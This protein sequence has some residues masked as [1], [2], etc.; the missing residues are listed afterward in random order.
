M[1]LEMK[2]M[3]EEYLGKKSPGLTDPNTRPSVDLPLAKVKP[4]NH[5]SPSTENNGALPKENDGQAKGASIP[6]Q[7]L[8][9]LYLFIILCFDTSLHRGK[10]HRKNGVFDGVESFDELPKV[11]SR[12][13][14][15][16]LRE[17][18]GN[19][20]IR[21]WRVHWRTY[22]ARC[23]FDS[24]TPTVSSRGSVVLSC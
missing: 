8:T 2:A 17:Q 1:R 12:Y 14:I 10:F 3:F 11:A 7:T 23:Q 24:K 16:L 5:G 6:P 20:R 15:F 21:T 13:L 18:P 9:P 19:I 4:S 22:W